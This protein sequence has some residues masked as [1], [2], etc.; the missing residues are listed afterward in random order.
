M[1]LNY[2]PALVT[3][4]LV[5]SLDAADKNS[6]PGTGTTWYDISG[7]GY[8]HTIVNSPTHNGTAFVLNGTQGFTY[9]NMVTNNALCTVVIFY[10]TTDVQELWVK[11][12][13]GAY[14]ISAA[15]PGSGYYSENSGSP[16]NYVDLNVVTDPNISARNGNYHM[17]EAKNVNFSTWNQLNW[18]LYGGDWNLI[19]TVSKIMVYNRT[20]TAKESEQNYL[21]QKSRFGL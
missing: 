18:F 1:A 19:G 7:N 8:H 4:G 21:T 17:W 12:N 9:A 2:G 20:I 6:Y 11:G 10:K 13:S 16:I 15:Y 14:Y 3:N 5:L